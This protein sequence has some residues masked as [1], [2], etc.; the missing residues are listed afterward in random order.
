MTDPK[1]KELVAAHSIAKKKGYKKDIDSFKNLLQN[2]E[3]ALNDIYSEVQKRGYSKDLDSFQSLIGVKKKGPGAI[4]PKRASELEQKLPI[5]DNQDGSSVTSKPEI[6]EQ[7]EESV[8]SEE[9]VKKFKGETKLELMEEGVPFGSPEYEKQMSERVKAKAAD[10]D[11]LSYSF[12]KGKKSTLQGIFEIPNFILDQVATAGLDE[13]QLENLNSLEVD[14]RRRVIRDMTEE[15]FQ[16]MPEL[17]KAHPVAKWFFEDGGIEK[18]QRIAEELDKEHD[19]MQKASKQ[20]DQSIGE[21]ILDLDVGQASKR[22]ANAL[23]ETTPALM[24]TMIPY[25]GITTLGVQTAAQKSKQLQQDGEDLGLATSTNAVLSGAVEAAVESISGKLGKKFL[26]SFDVHPKATVKT[27][28]DLLGKMTKDGFLEGGSEASAEIANSLIDNLVSGKEDAFQEVMTRM[29]DAFII[30]GTMGSGLAGSGTGGQMARQFTE[31]KRL[32]KDISGGSYESLSKMFEGDA[33]IDSEKLDIAGRSYSKKFLERDLTKMVKNG[34]ISEAEMKTRMYTFNEVKSYYDQTQDLDLTKDQKVKA[35]NLIKRKSQIE[36]Q[37]E[38]KDP[39]L[40]KKK[41]AEINEINNRLENIQ[42]EVEVETETPK[43]NNNQPTNSEP[44]KETE[45]QTTQETQQEILR[46][47]DRASQTQEVDEDFSSKTTEDLENEM[48]SIEDNKD[49]DLENRFNK[50]EKEVE[51]REWRSVLNAPLSEI[52]SVVDNLLEKDK[53]M[54]NNYGTFIEKR[55]ANETKEIVKKYSNSVSK[56][57]AKTD[58]KNSFFGNPSTWYADGL[59]MRESVRAFTEQGGSFKELLSSVKNEFKSDG[60]TEA[61]AASVIN[62]KLQEVKK[63]NEATPEGNTDTDG[64][65]RPDVIEG[66]NTQKRQEA[67]PVVDDTTSQGTTEVNKNTETT[68]PKITT[69]KVNP[70]GVKGQFDVD[71]NAEGNVVNIRSAKDGREISKFVERKSKRTGRTSLRPNSNY[72]RIEAEAL[73][74]LT[75]NQR[76]ESNKAKIF[77]AIDNYVPTTPYEA[78]LN[79]F[80]S[81]GNVNSVSAQKESGLSQGE[82]RWATSFKKDNELPSVERASENISDDSDVEMDQIEIRDAINEILR[83]KQSVSE[84]QNEILSLQ[85]DLD[86][87]QSEQELNAFLGSLSS[88]E[89]SLVESQM[90]EDSYLEELTYQEKLEYYEDKFG[91]TEERTQAELEGQTNRESES[92]SSSIQEPEGSP[93]K[94]E[95]LNT[96]QPEQNSDGEVQAMGVTSRNKVR[97]SSLGEGGPVKAL[98]EIQRRTRRFWNQTFKTN[99]GA[100]KEI[101]KIMRSLGFEMSAATNALEHELSELKKIITK[102]SKGKNTNSFNDNAKAVN[103]YLL[104]AEGADVSFLSKEQKQKI[105]ALRDRVDNLSGKLDDKLEQQKSDLEEKLEEAEEGSAAESSINDAIERVKALQETIRANK[106]EYLH[107]SYDAFKDP[108]YLERLTGKNVNKE[109]RRRIDNAVQYLM[110]ESAD[111]FGTQIK[112]SD[113]RRR[114]FKYLESLKNESDLLSSALQGEKKAPFFK[115]RND[116]IPQVFRELLGESKDPMLN[117]AS[118]VFKI[119]NYLASADYQDTMREHLLSTGQ[120]TYEAQAG[121]TKLTSDNEAWSGLSGV[122]VPQE[123]A[124]AIKDLQPLSTIEND[125]YKSW[126]AFAAFTKLGKTVLSPT[127]T[128]RNFYS[129]MVLGINAGFFFA[130]NPS[131][132]KDSLSMSWGSK[133]SR[134]E[135]K[136]ET[137]K[138]FEFGVLGDGAVSR[139]VMETMN[140]FTSDLERLSNQSTGKRVFNTVKKAYALGDDFYKVLGYY[141]YKKRYEESGM[142]TADAEAKAAQ[143]IRDTFPTYSMLPKNIQR[144]RRVPLVG[145]FVSFPYEAVR[146]SANTMKYL[147]ED[148]KAGRK[149]MAAKQAAGFI[150]ANSFHLGAAQLTRSLMGFDDDDDDKI[151]DMLPSYQTNSLLWYFGKDENEQPIFMDATALIPSEVYLKPLRTLLNDR[152]GRDVEDNIAQSLK[153]AVSPYI[154]FDISFK[155]MNELFFN[156]D[157]YDR[158]IYEGENLIDGVFN[159]PDKVFQ[160]YMKNAG[161]GA[162][163]NVTE[164]ARANNIRPEFFGDKFTSYG[165]EYTNTDALLGLMGFRFTTMNYAAGMT[166]LGYKNKNTFDEKK[167]DITSVFKSNRRL[168]GLRINEAVSEY[169]EANKEMAESLMIGVKGARKLGVSEA[170]IFR[171]YKKSGISKD[172]VKA[173][174]AGII[175]PLKEITEQSVISKINDVDLKYNEEE[176][177]SKIQLDYLYNVRDFNQ[178]I[179]NKNKD[180]LEE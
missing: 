101:G 81:G 69:K 89:L 54:P 42:D 105:D 117:Y 79:Y 58:F 36:R 77:K 173:L 174:M 28:K 175:P 86:S 97:D 179:K 125:F 143:R 100:S 131:K 52:V 41:R 171:A 129:G 46:E 123:L 114:V 48:F 106:G 19:F 32:D 38:G 109:G 138:L 90:A 153:E 141:S 167:K 172:D 72:S 170:D 148:I 137:D 17:M 110:D 94:T 23:A 65:V 74:E 14:G 159:N 40:V 50:I 84:I 51:K 96:D 37:I 132:M 155:T 78:A 59:K 133:K 166:S 85:E 68:Q 80:A 8:V 75:T 43:T 140:D 73:G 67:Q 47:E 7:N 34:E 99:A 151:R 107:R 25:V 150:I 127:T 112:E 180:L 176:K 119:S 95:R 142:S 154:G 9:R 10:D 87:Q 160:H 156:R 147:R 82:V 122:Y 149:S 22:I 163:A 56:I 35:A 126:V 2:D 62:N 164:F 33:D 145:T 5:V 70:K 24:E 63:T 102:S 92:S 178:I 1:N 91:T 3:D 15:A 165:R 134:G 120:G 30:G 152:E 76:R 108:K 29:V 93:A 39:A 157:V 121:Y 162:Y 20:Y 104:G 113:A 16:K 61:E 135:L 177:K 124:D 118:T 83:T 111:L 60:F 44:N 158:R 45:T 21:D 71:V 26:I 88:E 66:G 31:A 11:S 55:D 6:S 12:E 139:E 53:S 18:T 64:S 116:K 98:D 130:S 13:K 49:Y 168:D 144:L 27:I 4:Y 128:L 57:E 146:T 136:S 115:K 169:E 161:P 103:D